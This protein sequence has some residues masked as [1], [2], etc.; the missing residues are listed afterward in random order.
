[1]AA[2]TVR[3]ATVGDAEQ[4][5]RLITDLG[6][7]T[8]ARQMQK[9][10]ESILREPDYRT[11]VACAEAETVGFIGARV[12][13]LYE[14]DG[15]YGQIMAMAVAPG[16]RRRGIGRALLDAAESWLVEQGARVLVVGSGNRRAE[17]HAF[18]ER[19]GYAFTGRRYRK[20]L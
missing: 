7:P 16:H 6:Y 11:L 15:H 17:A 13:L 18:Y 1:M 9:R 14:S 12:G 5:A 19:C 2:I 4:I 20:S 10:L 8:S 3:D